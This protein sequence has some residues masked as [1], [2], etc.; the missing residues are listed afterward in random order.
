MQFDKKVFIIISVIS[1][2]FGRQQNN[3]VK[4]SAQ[5]CN[6][7]C[8]IYGIFAQKSWGLHDSQNQTTYTIFTA[9]ED[10]M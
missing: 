1:H 5:K 8:E 9:I 6:S 4:Q 3:R 7:E 2:V 10:K